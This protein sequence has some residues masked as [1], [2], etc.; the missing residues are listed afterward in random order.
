DLDKQF[1]SDLPPR[2]QYQLRC[3]LSDA[4]KLQSLRIVN[5]L[6]M[7]ALG[8]PAMKVGANEFVYTDQT[9]GPRK[10]QITHDWVERSA[11][12]PPEPPAS[13]VSPTDQ[14][15][16]KGTDVV[17]K[18]TPAVDPD[19]DKVVDYQFELSNRADLRWPLSLN[20]YKL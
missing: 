18:W 13:A 11:S 19:G 20:F 10:V 6:Q 8:M 7:A 9:T 3:Q 5:D 17:F 15:T 14:G 16:S 4:A 12:R 1:Q 2:Y